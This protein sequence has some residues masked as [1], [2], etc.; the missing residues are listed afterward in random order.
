MYK[1]TWEAH[2]KQQ[3]VDNFFD[4]LPVIDVR[5]QQDAPVVLETSHINKGLMDGIP[6]CHF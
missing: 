1:N 2:I 3:H 6:G 4:V 5:Y